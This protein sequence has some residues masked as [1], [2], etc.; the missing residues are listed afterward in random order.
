MTSLSFVPL[1][2]IHNSLLFGVSCVSGRVS[3]D[4]GIIFD[5]NLIGKIY[6]IFGRQIVRHIFSYISYIN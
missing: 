6:W 1:I 3:T 2:K 5:D 4:V